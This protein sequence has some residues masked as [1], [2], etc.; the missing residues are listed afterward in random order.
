MVSQRLKK[1]NIGP[2]FL[3]LASP[4]MGNLC[5]NSRELVRLVVRK[6]EKEL[7]PGEERS[8]LNSAC[9]RLVLSLPQI[10]DNDPEMERRENLR[11]FSGMI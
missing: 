11:P 3:T 10:D 9:E 5:C 1:T 8:W 6:E 4:S 2:G 7:Q